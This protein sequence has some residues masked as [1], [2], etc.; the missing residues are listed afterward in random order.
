MRIQLVTPAGQRSRAGN[1]ATATRWARLLRETGHQVNVTEHATGDSRAEAML[2]LHA[3]RS[4]DSIQAFD[5]RHPERPLVVTLT[6]TDIY[7]FQH[8]DRD[9]TLNSLERADALIGLH[10]R[11]GDDIPEQYRERLHTVFQSARPLP[12]SYRP[13]GG[14]A[15]TRRSGSFRILVAGH[16]RAE[17]DSLRAARA[18]RELPGDSGIEVI[19]VGRAHSP[20]WAEA[21]TREMADNPRFQWRGEVPHWRVRRLMARAQV[22]VISSVMEGGANVV[23]EACVAGLPVVASDI[24]GNRGLLGDDYPAYYP[25]Q[26]TAALRDLLLR[27]ERDPDFLADL[28]ERCAARA[29]W[30]QPEAERAGLERAL[31]FARA[32]AASPV[33]SH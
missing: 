27:V 11:V 25:T 2:A 5:E 9:T 23:S 29:P 21:A 14:A 32:R 26:D 7:G 1:R 15:K 22:M 12:D 4:A 28:R 19:N 8:S 3:W 16:L 30:F 20:D 18:A 33:S 6:G 10:D 24:P 17:K 13:G 31:A